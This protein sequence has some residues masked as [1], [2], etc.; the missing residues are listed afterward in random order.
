MLGSC[1]LEE[2]L[3]QLATKFDAVKEGGRENARWHRSSWVAWS[4]GILKDTRRL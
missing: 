1:G 3:K 2:M 4:G